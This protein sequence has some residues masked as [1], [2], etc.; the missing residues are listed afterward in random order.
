MNIRLFRNG[1]VLVR[2][3][4]QFTRVIRIWY[5]SVKWKLQETWNMK[6]IVF[7]LQLINSREGLGMFFS[8][9]FLIRRLRKY[10]A[11][12]MIV[13]INHFLIDSFPWNS[14]IFSAVYYV[15]HIVRFDL[16]GLHRFLKICFLSTGCSFVSK[17][18]GQTFEKHTLQK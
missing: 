10:T 14:K 11:T 12:R 8:S 16:V 18:V 15:Q 7:Y 2:S 13:E 3:P 5:G 4:D 9:A 6:F 17:K 1:S